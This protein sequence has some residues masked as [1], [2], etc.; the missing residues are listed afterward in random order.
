MNRCRYRRSG[1]VGPA[2]ESDS[3]SG[4]TE[5]SIEEW[6]LVPG[7]SSCYEASSWGRI[8]RAAAARG[9]RPRRILRP[10]SNRWGYL[11]V[12]IS[13]AGSE[14]HRFVHRLVAET[15]VGPPPDCRSQINHLSGDKHDN[16]PANLEWAGAATNM[17]HAATLGLV[18][19]GQRN[20][21]ARLKE[22]EV[23]A[24]RDLAAA[25][26]SQRE[27]ARRLG[28]P[29]STVGDVVRGRAW[30][31]LRIPIAAAACGETA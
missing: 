21:S 17:R 15:F 14:K 30:A 24:I 16:R 11:L 18:A 23:L 4:S 25:S 3:G 9:T 20:R 13:L 8:R 7:T 19:R 2:R 26:T 29:R 22:Q 28:V 31:W 12:A 6:R 1:R 10:R 5:N 27:I